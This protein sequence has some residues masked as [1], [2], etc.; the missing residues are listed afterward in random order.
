MAVV[1]QNMAHQNSFAEHR[2]S[3]VFY[4]TIHKKKLIEHLSLQIVIFS[5][6]FGVLATVIAIMLTGTHCKLNFWLTLCFYAF[7][8]GPFTPSLLAWSNQY[9][10]LTATLCGVLDIGIA[11]GAFVYNWLCGYLLSY[12][13]VS[14]LYYLA[15]ATATA[16]LLLLILLQLRGSF[17]QNR[18]HRSQ[19][20]VYE[21]P[22]GDEDQSALLQ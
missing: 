17:H 6:A 7:V 15:T 4:A 2:Y 8:S 13:D 11:T 9:L 14:I 21:N 20:N 16:S 3:K 1:G 12:Y 10:T 22:T 18:E 5:E 19:E